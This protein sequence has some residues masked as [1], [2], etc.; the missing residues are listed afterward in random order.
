MNYKLQQPGGVT[1]EQYNNNPRQSLRERNW[2]G[3]PW[4]VFSLNFDTKLS[5]NLS[6]NYKFFGLIAERNSVLHK[7][8][9]EIYEGFNGINCNNKILIYFLI[10][11]GELKSPL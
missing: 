1:D 7:K 9:A 2:F 11:S 8:K 10:F 4:N 5:S 3:T 6:S